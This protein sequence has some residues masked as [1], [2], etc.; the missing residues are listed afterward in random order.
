MKRLTAT[1]AA[2]RFSEMLDAVERQ[3]ETFV[4]V[5]NGRPVAH[6][7]PASKAQGAAV[8]SVLRA[9]PRDPKWADELRELRAGLGVEERDWND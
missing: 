9:N 6:V 2:R 5:R 3:G 8:K 1:D 4:V 7:G